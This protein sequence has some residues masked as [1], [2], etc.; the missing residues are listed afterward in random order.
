MCDL[1]SRMSTRQLTNNN[2]HGDTLKQAGYTAV[3]GRL[4]LLHRSIQ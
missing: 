3:A 1:D 2:M 4:G